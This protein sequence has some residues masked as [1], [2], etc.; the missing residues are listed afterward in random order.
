[1]FDAMGEQMQAARCKRKLLERRCAYLVQ[2]WDLQEV[3][4]VVHAVISAWRSC[5]I[6]LRTKRNFIEALD[7]PVIDANLASAAC[8]FAY[9][10]CEV[11]DSV[12]LRLRGSEVLDAALLDCTDF[13]CLTGCNPEPLEEDDVR[14]AGNT[15]FIHK[16]GALSDSC[17]ESMAFSDLTAIKMNEEDTDHLGYFSCARKLS[18]T[19]EKT[20]EKAAQ[21][22]SRA[23][24]QSQSVEFLLSG[25]GKERTA[26][27]KAAV[28]DHT[29]PCMVRSSSLT[30]RTQNQ[31]HVCQSARQPA[32]VS[33]NEKV[34]EGGALVRPQRRQP[35]AP[36]QE[37]ASPSANASD[38]KRLKGP[39]RFFYDT[40]SYTGC[41][42]FGGPKIVDKKENRGMDVDAMSKRGSANVPSSA[43]PSASPGVTRFRSAP[44]HAALR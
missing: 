39:E 30:L 28:S 40:S 5:V 35:F 11:L 22:S 6:L 3:D 32:G 36:C 25:V 21:Y 8:A 7:I 33:G 12:L 15:G 23:L 41:A 4:V 16:Y 37:V 18:F 31:Q 29:R 26:S 34:P 24:V 17:A 38:V 9:W 1:M 19:A 42:R 43:P 14:S 13:S 44:S 27:T 10:R 2:S 20:A